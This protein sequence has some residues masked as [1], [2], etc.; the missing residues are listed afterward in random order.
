MLEMVMRMEKIAALRLI[1]VQLGMLSDGASLRELD[2]KQSFGDDNSDDEGLEPKDIDT[3][4]E[5]VRGQQCD[6]ADV[7][8]SN[9]LQ[10]DT[11]ISLAVK[12]RMFCLFFSL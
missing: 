1:F 4:A 10:S 8:A 3:V 12:H 9:A 5:P 6:V 11:S 7:G 2:C